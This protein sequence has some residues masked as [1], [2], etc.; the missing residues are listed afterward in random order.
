L[1]LN[2]C[3]ARTERHI[4][5]RPRLKLICILYPAGTSTS[6]HVQWELEVGANIIMAKQDDFH[7]LQDEILH[8]SLANPKSFWAHQ[9]DHLHWHKKPNTILHQGRKTLKNGISHP[10]WSWFPD[11][12]ISTCYNCVDRHVLAGRGDNVAIYWDSPVSN[13]KQQFT[14]RQLLE[15]VEALAGALRQEGVKKGDVVMVYSKSIR[16]RS[17][18]TKR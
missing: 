11:G 8:D 7:H 6:L 14:Y 17:T 2:S 15:E 4:E 10:D 12:E 3:R 16:L 9:A 18:R 5:D 1:C 13:T